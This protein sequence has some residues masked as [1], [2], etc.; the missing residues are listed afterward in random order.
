MNKQNEDQLEFVFSMNSVLRFKCWTRGWCDLTMTILGERVRSIRLS[1][2]AHVSS[3]LQTVHR[4]DWKWQLTL[5][6][7]RLYHHI[8]PCRPRYGNESFERETFCGILHTY[9]TARNR[10]FTNTH[11]RFAYRMRSISF[12]SVHLFQHHIVFI[13]FQRLTTLASHIQL[14]HFRRTSDDENGQTRATEND[15]AIYNCR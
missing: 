3:S 6:C 8:P 13:W 10:I 15:S 14:T 9:Y 5:P 4:M 1:A 11:F 2:R 7:S 12:R